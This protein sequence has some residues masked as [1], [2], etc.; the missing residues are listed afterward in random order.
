MEFSKKIVRWGIWYLTM[1][2]VLLMVSYFMTGSVPT[3]VATLAGTVTS[4]VIVTY[5]AKSGVENV[6]KIKQGGTK[7]DKNLS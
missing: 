1:V 2:T 3:E 5:A 6:Q 4:G 7:S